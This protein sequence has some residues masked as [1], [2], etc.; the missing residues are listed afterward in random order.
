MP[1]W[2]HGGHV[3]K[4][5]RSENARQCILD[6]RRRADPGMW[7]CNTSSRQKCGTADKMC[8]SDQDETTDLTGQRGEEE[9]GEEEGQGHERAWK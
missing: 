4:P 8:K 5:T 2:V 1:R 3:A 6:L 7:V 9:A